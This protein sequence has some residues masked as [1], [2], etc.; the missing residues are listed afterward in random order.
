MKKRSFCLI[1]DSTS[2]HLFPC[3]EPNCPLQTTSLTYKF[4]FP[5]SWKAI[6]DT[7][8]SRLQHCRPSASTAI[9]PSR[10][11]IL[12]L[13]R[14]SIYR[15]E[16]LPSTD[17]FLATSLAFA[18]HSKRVSIRLTGHSSTCPTPFF[19]QNLRPRLPDLHIQSDSPSVE[20]K[21]QN[22]SALQLPLY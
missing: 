22:F 10:P 17:E 1:V 8:V 18:R 20:Q 11:P 7:T 16:D 3:E 14:I 21:S 19:L 4:I 15:L 5:N 2:I 12:P 6:K 9:P 13:N